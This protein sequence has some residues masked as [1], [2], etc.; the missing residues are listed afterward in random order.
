MAPPP[1]FIVLTDA[2]KTSLR[3][4]FKNGRNHRERQRAECILLNAQGMDA[5][6]LSKRYGICY[7]TINLWLKRYKLDDPHC[8][9]DSPR[10][11]RP[12]RMNQ[13]TQK[14]LEIL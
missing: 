4:I 3:S 2:S 9:L 14:K 10:P 11:G 5:R 1:R 13:Q 6:T 7:E 12:P 8:L